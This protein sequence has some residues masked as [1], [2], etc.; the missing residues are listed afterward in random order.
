MSDSQIVSTSLS[1][2]LR[3]A[4]VCFRAD[5]LAGGEEIHRQDD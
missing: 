4:D 3:V 1:K 2:T 5:L